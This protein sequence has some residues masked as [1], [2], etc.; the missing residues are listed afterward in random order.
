MFVGKE[1]GKTPFF[2]MGRAPVSVV[3]SSKRG[4]FLLYACCLYKQKPQLRNERLK[5][6]LSLISTVNGETIHGANCILY[7]IR[8]W[9]HVFCHM[10]CQM[11]LIRLL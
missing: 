3:I 9:H 11:V 4:S 7:C 8:I 10:F 1:G 6:F 5:P 2:F